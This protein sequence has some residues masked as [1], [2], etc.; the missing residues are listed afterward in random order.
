MSSFQ[1]SEG[2]SAKDT[3]HYQAN[4]YSYRKRAS[5][6]AENFKRYKVAPILNAFHHSVHYKIQMGVI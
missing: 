4:G 3:G 2:A 6:D 1:L 5:G